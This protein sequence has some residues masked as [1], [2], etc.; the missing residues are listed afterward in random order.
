M[1]Q[2]HQGMCIVVGGSSGNTAVHNNVAVEEV[3]VVVGGNN[4][5]KEGQWLLPQKHN[6]GKG[7]NQGNKAGVS[8]AVIEQVE[9][10][11]ARGPLSKAAVWAMAGEKGRLQWQVVVA[12]DGDDDDDDNGGVDGKGSS[13][14]IIVGMPRIAALIPIARTP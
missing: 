10:A 5:G 2:Y 14:E 13:C 1:L 11:A 3:C 7:K 8:A 9:G 6:Y 12:K 4:D